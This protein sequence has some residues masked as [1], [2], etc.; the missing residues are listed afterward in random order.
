[1]TYKD[2]IHCYRALLSLGQ[3]RLPAHLWDFVTANQIA[4]EP[5]VQAVAKKFGEVYQEYGERDEGGEMVM[6]GQIDILGGQIPK[7][8]DEAFVELS[9]HVGQEVSVETQSIE[10]DLNQLEERGFDLPGNELLPLRKHNLIK[11]KK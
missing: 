8:P 3:R 1:M 2:L 10:I 5:R 9:E 6:S 4:W 11:I 7:M